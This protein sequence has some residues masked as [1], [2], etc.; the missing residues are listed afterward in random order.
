[1]SLRLTAQGLYESM[2]ALEQLKTDFSEVLRAAFTNL[3]QEIVDEAKGNLQTNSSIVSAD[4]LNSVQVFEVGENAMGGMYGIVGSELEYAVFVEYGRGPVRPVVARVLHWVDPE[5]GED[6]YSM[7]AGP[8]Q[9]APFLE[10]AVI[11]KTDA[12]ADLIAQR[13]HEKLREAGF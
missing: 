8:T 9:P 10:P 7:Y 6:V 12:Y 11:V 2:D 3:L 4:L 1:M 5:T 13:V